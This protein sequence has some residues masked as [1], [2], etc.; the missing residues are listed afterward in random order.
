VRFDWPGAL[1]P[2][3]GHDLVSTLRVID[4]AASK[5][6]TIRNNAAEFYRV[7]RANGRSDGGRLP[8]IDNGV[9]RKLIQFLENQ[10]DN[11]RIESRLLLSGRGP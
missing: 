11:L 2:V 9:V 5:R 6:P 7:R 10:L 4:E 8:S 3:D 1:I